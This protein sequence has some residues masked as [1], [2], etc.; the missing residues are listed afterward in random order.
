MG[1]EVTNVYLVKGDEICL[2]M[3]KRGFGQG[4][5]NGTGGKIMD[6]EAIEE[7]AKREAKEEFGVDLLELRNMGEI[8]FVFKNGFEHNCHLFLCNKWKGEPFESEEM[9]PRWFKIS[10]LPFDNMWKTDKHW[11]PIILDDKRIEA[12]FYFNDDAKTIE[13]FNLK[14][15]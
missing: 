9:K 10:S 6:N 15:I 5:W 8:L 4:L 3:K 13:K 11:L 2:G 1:K 12:V 7:A 14:E